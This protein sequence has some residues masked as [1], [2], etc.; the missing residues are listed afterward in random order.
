MR[1]LG[2]FFFFCWLFLPAA[3]A[4]QPDQTVQSVRVELSFPP[5]RALYP[6]LAERIELSFKSVGEKVLLGKNVSTVRTLS[7]V[8]AGT[9]KK[10]FDVVLRGFQVD[11]LELAAGPETVLKIVLRPSQPI[12]ERATL[13]LNATGLAPGLLQFLD[14]NQQLFSQIATEVLSGVPVEA[15]DWAEGVMLGV[16]EQVV[17]TQLPGFSVHM[18]LK[19]GQVTQITLFLSP[20]GPVVRSAAVAVSSDT[21]PASVIRP[22]ASQAE[23]QAQMLVGI[24]IAFLG[25]YKSQLEQSLVR[26]INGHP[27]MK[28]WGLQTRLR[29]EPGE[30]TA[31]DLAVNSRYGRFFAGL[32]INVGARAPSPAWASHLGAFWGRQELFVENYLALTTLEATWQ[33]GARCQVAPLT[34]VTGQVNLRT[35]RWQYGFAHAVD[36]LQIGLLSDLKQ[37]LLEM[38]IGKETSDVLVEL[39]GNTKRNYWLRLTAQI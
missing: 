33:L 12:I 35:G 21:I 15:L 30:V 4:Q 29:I 2:W 19:V 18:D 1:T 34:S 25:Q 11:K 16:L 6:D 24:P 32:T 17:A 10:V 14:E 20:T 9:I 31:V 37:G 8:L 38:S 5:G 36:D 3:A 28:K 27:S 23:G 13:K 39:V 26:Q 7:D 22:L